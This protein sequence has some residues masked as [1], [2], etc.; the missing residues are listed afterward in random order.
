MIKDDNI[1]G[2][3]GWKEFLTTR[4]ELLN[5]FDRARNKNISRP[6][7]TSHG[8]AGEAIFRKWLEEF[9]PKRYAV[10]SGFI[11]PNT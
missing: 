2:F 8:N 6:V 7:R 10:T 1:Y 5:E 4:E 9:L 11:I 3:Y